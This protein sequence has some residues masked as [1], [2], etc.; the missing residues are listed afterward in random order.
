MQNVDVAI[1]DSVRPVVRLCP[2]CA[3]PMRIVSVESVS[4]VSADMQRQRI[5]CSVCELVVVHTIAN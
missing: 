5:R 1:D 2:V 4:G 3:G